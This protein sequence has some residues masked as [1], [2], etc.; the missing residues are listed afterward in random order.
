MIIRFPCLSCPQ[1]Q[2]PNN[3][4]FLRFQIPRRRVDGKHL[5]RFYNETPLA[6][7][8]DEALGHFLNKSI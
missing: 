8:V 7:S 3:R 1:L 5:M 6:Y 4:L 2:I